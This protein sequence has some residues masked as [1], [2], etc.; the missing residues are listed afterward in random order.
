MKNLT[1]TLSIFVLFTSLSHAQ[2][3]KYK[4]KTKLK[5]QPQNNNSNVVVEKKDAFGRKTDFRSQQIKSKERKKHVNL[6]PETA[7]G[8]EVITNFNFSNTSLVELTKH[9]QKL[10]GI[11][12]LWGKEVKGNVSILAP[13]SITVGE[14]WKA[15]LT[16]LNVNGYTLIKTGAFYKII[17]SRNARQNPIKTYTGSFTP[18]VEN[19]LMKVIPIKNIKSEEIYRNLRSFVTREGRIINIQ[20]TNT[21]IIL[22]TGV[23]INRLSQLIKLLDIPGH[24]ETLHI[25]PMKHSSAQE[26]ARLLDTI[27]KDGSRSRK[28]SRGKPAN[29]NSS[30]IAKIIAEPRTNSIIAL[31]N[32]QGIKEL[33]SL[34][35]K[36][37][38]KYGAQSA[39]KIHVYYLNYGSA[40]DLSQT[41]ST[42]VNNTKQTGSRNIS[43][44]SLTSRSRLTQSNDVL[45]SANIRI[46][47][48]EPN[49]ALVITASPT[50]WLT[51]EQVIKKLDIPRD[52]VYVEGMI[53]ET[54]ISRDRDIGISIIGAYGTGAGQKAGF[55]PNSG[56]VDLI[57]NNFTNLGGLFVG[58]W[59][60][61]RGDLRYLRNTGNSE[62]GYRT[63][64]RHRY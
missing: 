61:K 41:L 8:P 34:I 20:E 28:L 47:A 22:D 49:N 31:T 56:I 23:N 35:A 11:N 13:S 21:I 27:L 3:Q 52:Q 38:V 53:M 42:L 62:L 45:F 54:N 10:T 50:D 4:A 16:A 40:K 39:D 2:F 44:S 59:C 25:I 12:L 18:S 33:K 58:G 5:D 6:N 26:I 9:M 43:R 17:Q 60:R 51:I 46:T 19:F 37:D 7:F 55:V 63:D 30:N 57:S 48:D 32:A 15:Y 64:P 24:E 1:T 36:L 29:K 14:A